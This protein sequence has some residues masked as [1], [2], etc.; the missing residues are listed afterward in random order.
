[1]ANLIEMDREAALDH[2]KRFTYVD[3]LPED[4]DPFRKLLQ[5][6]S[7]VPPGEVDKLLLKTVSSVFFLY[8]IPQ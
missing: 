1:M 8:F 2:W 4:I 7:K 6:Y 3:D 5:E